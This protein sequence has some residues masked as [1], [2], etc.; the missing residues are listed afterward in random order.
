MEPIPTTGNWT[1][2]VENEKCVRATLTLALSA[3]RWTPGNKLRDM[4]SWA[5][6]PLG[7]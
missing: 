4:A 5:H 1:Q 3:L 2:W 7:E 6:V